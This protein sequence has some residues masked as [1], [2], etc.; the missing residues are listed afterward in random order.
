MSESPEF[1][2]RNPEEWN[3]E[4]DQKQPNAG[5]EEGG[6]AAGVADAGRPRQQLS[7][8]CAQAF[9]VL[10]VCLVHTSGTTTR[11]CG[12]LALSVTQLDT[13]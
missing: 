7:G 13:N 4:I 5:A 6:C 1:K 3:T 10:S 12:V 11:Q 2:T 9:V 8:F